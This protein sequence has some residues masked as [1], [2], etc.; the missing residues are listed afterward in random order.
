ME[1]Q[2]NN[3]IMHR[4]NTSS[5]TRLLILFILLVS[6]LKQTPVNANENA[7]TLQSL[8]REGNALMNK[9]QLLNYQQA[10]KKYQKALTLEPENSD[11][12]LMT[13][14]ALN[15]IMRVK[16]NGNIICINGGTQDN[17]EN[18][19]VWAK[20]AP[21]ALRLSENVLKKRPGDKRAL[22]TYAE[23]YL[24][25]SS[26]FGILKAIFKGAADQYKRNANALITKYPKADDALGDIYMGAFYAVA[27]WPLSS[28]KKARKHFKNALKL[29]PKSVRSHYY[30]GLQALLDNKYAEAKNEFEFV[31]K[32]P[33]TNGS[34]Y[35]YCSF[36]KKEAEKG[37][38]KIDKI[39]R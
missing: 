28:R 19:A 11:L 37:L 24:Y 21:E 35:D 17:N 26:S 8:V 22:L 12:M 25:L 20:L 2:L 30:V 10:L 33:C 23:S 32:N 36:M 3:M 15:H 9:R 5:Q 4:S 34:E 18:K 6:V 16:T 7:E 39:S 27:P 31:I 1:L 13:A 14:D 38:V 29:A